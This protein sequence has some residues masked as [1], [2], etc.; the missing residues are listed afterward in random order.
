MKFEFTD[1]VTG[2]SWIEEYASIEDIKSEILD[3]ISWKFAFDCSV[4]KKEVRTKSVTEHI[5]GM[6]EECSKDPSN[7]V[8]KEDEKDGREN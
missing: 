5:L 2:D 6:C 4:C 7:N 3:G 1:D 8:E